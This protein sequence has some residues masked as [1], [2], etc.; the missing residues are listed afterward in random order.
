MQ[1]FLFS[2]T[3]AA[4]LC[5]QN[6]LIPR[7]ASAAAS[8]L[9]PPR[10]NTAAAYRRPGLI[11]GRLALLTWRDCPSAHLSWV[12]P[13]P[14]V[15]QHAPARPAPPALRSFRENHSSFLRAALAMS[16][17]AFPC[18]PGSRRPHK[19]KPRQP[20]SLQTLLLGPP[21]LSSLGPA[22]PRARAGPSLQCLARQLPA[23]P[24]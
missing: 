9:L 16:T 2:M 23:R 24:G 11:S 10:L 20:S 13:A 5:T 3:R 7:A 4:L 12:D 17:G 21:S 14:Y 1:L 18:S 8:M 15:R 6:P 22:R 19:H